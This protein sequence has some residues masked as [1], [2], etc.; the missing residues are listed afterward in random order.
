MRWPFGVAAEDHDR[1]Y[2]DES[3][4]EDDEDGG[5]DALERPAPA[6]GL[7]GDERSAAVC[8]HAA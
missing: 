5:L 7:V 8:D 3:R 6:G 4:G 2:G 1:C